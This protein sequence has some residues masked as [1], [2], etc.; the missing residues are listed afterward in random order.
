MCIYTDTYHINTYTYA[1]KESFDVPQLAQKV[2]SIK[3]MSSKKKGKK[4]EME[5]LKGL[6]DLKQV[7][8]GGRLVYVRVSYAVCLYAHMFVRRVFVW[9][10]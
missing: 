8:L 9:S 5:N 7:R 1:G 3:K 2:S 4:T 6:A 10:Y